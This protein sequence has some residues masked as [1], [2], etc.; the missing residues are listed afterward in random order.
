[1][2]HDRATVG[3]HIQSTKFSRIPDPWQTDIAVVATSRAFVGVD[4]ELF[5]TRG[6]P[7]QGRTMSISSV[8]EVDIARRT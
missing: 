3:R 5:V 8:G 4:R 2:Q 1:M 6:C 7:V